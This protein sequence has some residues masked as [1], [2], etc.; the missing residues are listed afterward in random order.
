[1]CTIDQTKVYKIKVNF[2]TAVLMKTGRSM[3]GSFDADVYR[4]NNIEA[5]ND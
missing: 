1:M 4:V 2:I 5:Q 3:L